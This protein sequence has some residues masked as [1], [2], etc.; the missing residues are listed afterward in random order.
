MILLSFKSCFHV[1]RV[2]SFFKLQIISTCSS[3]LKLLATWTLLISKIGD[4]CINDLRLRGNKCS[5]R[6]RSINVLTFTVLMLIGL[7]ILVNILL[8]C[9][10][11]KLTASTKFNATWL[12]PLLWSAG[13]SQL[14]FRIA[15]VS[16]TCWE[17]WYL[18]KLK[19]LTNSNV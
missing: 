3:A 1:Q 18:K 11:L 2:K 14:Y 17:T 15:S 10:Y 7:V 12:P 8:L 6:C 4:S 13:N 19:K 9:C 5:S 16:K